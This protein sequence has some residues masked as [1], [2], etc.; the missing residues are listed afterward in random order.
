MIAR[1]AI[2]R[3]VFD[4][5]EAATPQMQGLET[6]PLM[7]EHIDLSRQSPAQ[8]QEQIDN[9]L[10]SDREQAVDLSRPG[11]WR[12]A[13]FQLGSRQSVLVWTFHHAMLDGRSFTMLLQEA[14]DC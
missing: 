4:G 5:Q 12:L 9:W 6:A 3:S 10:E 2:L 13:W 1:H 7:L 8:Q 14:L 11:N